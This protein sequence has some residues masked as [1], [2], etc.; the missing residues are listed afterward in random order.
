[1]VSGASELSLALNSDSN[2]FVPGNAT[3]KAKASASRSTTGG[4]AIVDKDQLRTIREG[5]QA[6]KQKDALLISQQE[7]E[8]MK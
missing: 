3:D 7:L 5:A 4:A 8:R 1:M 2:S 6:G